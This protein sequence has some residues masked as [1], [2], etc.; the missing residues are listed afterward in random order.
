MKISTYNI[1]LSKERFF[2]NVGHLGVA[3]FCPQSVTESIAISFFDFDGN[4][5]IEELTREE[6][7]KHYGGLFCETLDVKNDLE[8]FQLLIETTNMHIQKQNG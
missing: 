3:L 8:A 7:Y 6:F 2:I 1:N 4:L 5:I